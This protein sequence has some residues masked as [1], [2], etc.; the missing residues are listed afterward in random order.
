ML[1]LESWLRRQHGEAGEDFYGYAVGGFKAGRR[2]GPQ[3]G[4]EE[5]WRG[6][7]GGFEES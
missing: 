6:Q 4:A 2:P 5:Q 1:P 7:Q 3:I